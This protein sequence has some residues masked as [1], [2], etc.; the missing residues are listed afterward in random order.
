M[1]VLE[2]DRQSKVTDIKCQSFQIFTFI[3]FNP[4]WLMQNKNLSSSFLTNITKKAV[5]EP[6][7]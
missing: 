1:K 5:F 6:L 4:Q 2:W 3:I 7:A